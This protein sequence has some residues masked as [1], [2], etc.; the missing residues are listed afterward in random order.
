MENEMRLSLLLATA[1]ALFGVGAA[2]AANPVVVMETTYGTIKIEL[3]EDQAPN[4]V[5]NFL[6]YVDSKH[7]DGLI[8]HRVIKDFMVQAG[9]FEPGMR[10][11]KG[12]DPIKNEP[13]LSN[14]RGTLAMGQIPGNPDSATSEFYINVVDNAHLDANAATKQPGY[15]VFGRVI[16]GMDAVDKI[17]AVKTASI[18]MNQNVPVEDIVIK[19]AKRAAK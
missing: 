9:G 4:T 1:I 13:K 10:E 2:H 8:F 5:K 12:K 14:K 15:T 18:A 7:F 17:A 19:S 11:R 3:F 16:D 6:G